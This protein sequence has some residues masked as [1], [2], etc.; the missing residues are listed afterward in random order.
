[1]PKMHISSRE[2]I[3]LILAGAPEIEVARSCADAGL[4]TPRG[5][6]RSSPDAVITDI[7]DA[8]VGNR[9]RDQGRATYCARA[10][11]T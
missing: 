1:L 5:L 7:P 9:R 11:P 4:A 6:R 10:T 8:A 2:A 3:E